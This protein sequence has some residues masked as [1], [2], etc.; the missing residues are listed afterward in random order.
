MYIKSMV[1]G[2]ALR[3]GFWTELSIEEL[4][5]IENGTHKR[6]KP[7]AGFDNLFSSKE[8][9]GDAIVFRYF[10]IKD[11]KCLMQSV[12]HSIL[13]VLE[14]FKFRNVLYEV[15]IE[16]VPGTP[17]GMMK[18]LYSFLLKKQ[19]IVSSSTLSS[20]AYKVWLDII[21]DNHGLIIKIDEDL[22]LNHTLM[23]TIMTYVTGSKDIIKYLDYGHGGNSDATYTRF[24]VSKDKI[25]HIG[26][27]Q[28]TR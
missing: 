20:Q 21:L 24:L 9:T 11:T 4:H 3:S 15:D 5:Y 7:E 6:I 23:G 28:S 14:D 22:D 12:F 17:Q 8:D 18:N 25:L 27:K 10:I 2:P 26:H 16:K 1:V 19:P 13:L